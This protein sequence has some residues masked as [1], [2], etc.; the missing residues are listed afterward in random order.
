MLYHQTTRNWK[1]PLYP[2]FP[3]AEYDSR[4]NR[5][6]RYMEAEKVD[7]LVLW[8]EANI[9][10]F[11]GFHNLHWSAR[12][13]QCAVF[14]IP[15]VGEPTIIAP[16]FFLGVVEGLTYLSDIRLQSTPHVTACIRNL[17]ILVADTVKDLGCG[18]GRVALE[19]GYLGGMCV[20]RPIN[21]IDLLRA[22]LDGATI[23]DGA[24]LI[25]KCRV[26]KSPAEVDALK[27]ATQAVVDSYGAL[28]EQFELGMTEHDISLIVRKE[29]LGR[30]DDCP[31]PFIVASS[32]G[33]PMADV[34]AHRGGDALK[35]GDRVVLEPLPTSKGYFGSCCRVLNIGPISEESQRR[36]EFMETLQDRAID[37][38][39]PGVKTGKITEIIIEGNK[40]A[41]NPDYLLDMAGHGVGLSFQEPPAIALNEEFEI[42]E[43][44]VL[45]VETW[46]VGMDATSAQVYAV[47]DYVVVTK[48][49][50]E[51][52]P[53]YPRELRSLSGK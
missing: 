22:S 13:L 48:D 27:V 36:A 18:N 15:L 7:V 30:T 45:A 6:K 49:G 17:P 9:R 33:I 4:I 3:K 10:Y 40:E 38:V 53:G 16:D 39:K 35:L 14:V 26:I 42:E 52:F 31:L 20:P 28:A 21:D 25:W 2:D 51:P 5:L 8:D 47:E 41:G 37:I 1:E 32:R 46:E 29:I 23:V 12:T 50:C 24:S 44:M 11:S 34:P 19:S 43:G